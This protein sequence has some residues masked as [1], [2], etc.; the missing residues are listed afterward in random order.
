MTRATFSNRVKRLF[1]FV[2][3]FDVAGFSFDGFPDPFVSLEILVG[4]PCEPS[5]FC[6]NCRFKASTDVKRKIVQ[7]IISF[8]S[9]AY[10]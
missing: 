3:P 10:I 2:L 5:W 7:T 1:P 9:N 6:D 8:M 4:E